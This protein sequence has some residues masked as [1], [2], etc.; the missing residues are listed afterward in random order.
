M[1]NLKNKTKNLVQF[2]IRMVN[3]FQRLETFDLFIY[4]FVLI[5]QQENDN[6]KKI[7]KIFCVESYLFHH[8]RQTLLWS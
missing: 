6:C 7:K 5:Q 3:N 2:I 8:R 4:S 1:T